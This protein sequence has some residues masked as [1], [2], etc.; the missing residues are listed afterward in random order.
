MR[1]YS[2]AAIEKRLAETAHAPGFSSW[3]AF[4]IVAAGNGRTE[5]SLPIRPDMC[6]HHGYVHGGV[7][8]A[9]ADVASAWAAATVSGDVVT[10]SITMH[11][12]A[13]A[14]G[15]RLVV[16][17]AVLKAGR[18]QASVE[19]KVSAV[20]ADGSEKLCGASMASIAVLGSKAG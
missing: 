19:A 10:G 16:R 5:L 4:D 20:S 1:D 8:A 7:V 17:A 9:L 11:Y 3:L 18:R 13:P 12:V 6:Q 14:L 15:D 2:D